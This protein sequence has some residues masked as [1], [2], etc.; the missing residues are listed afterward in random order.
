MKGPGVPTSVLS[1]TTNP[2]DIYIV[3]KKGIITK[4]AN[5]S[6]G[7]MFK[8]LS[9]QLIL[10]KGPCFIFLHLTETSSTQQFSTRRNNREGFSSFEEQVSGLGSFSAESQ[11]HETFGASTFTDLSYLNS[12]AFTQRSSPAN[13][14]FQERNHQNF[15]DGFETLSLTECNSVASLDIDKVICAK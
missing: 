10:F 5:S 14:C 2:C 12:E 1:C 11:V 4:A 3:S 8:V 6:S 15:E 9:L 7:G 13:S